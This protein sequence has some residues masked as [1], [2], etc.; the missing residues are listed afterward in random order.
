VLPAFSPD[1]SRIAYTRRSWDTF[2]APVT[3]GE[4]RLLLAN[5]T[6]LSWIDDRH[7][8]FS[9]IKT[10]HHLALIT[11]TESRTE[12]RDVYVPQPQEGMVHFSALSPD[13]KQALLGEMDRNGMLPCRLVPF[14]G[15][16]MGKPVGPIP[17][18]CEGVGW[19]PDGKWMYLSADAGSGTHIWRQRAAGG[20]PEQLTF[21]T[22][23][24]NGVAVTPDGKSLITSVGTTQNSVWVHDRDG[25][26]QVSAEGSAV[27]PFFSPDGK[28]LYYITKQREFGYGELWVTDL[29]SGRAERVLAG[30]LINRVSL[31]RDGRLIAYTTPDD[32]VWI[33]PLDR[34]LSPRKLASAKNWV[35][36]GSSGDVFFMGEDGA[37]N[38]LYRVRQ[39]GSGRQRVLE[40]PILRFISLSPDEHWA[41]VSVLD[42]ENPAGQRLYAYPIGG[43]KPITVCRRCWFS[44]APDGG[45][46][47]MSFQGVMPADTMT[48][49]VPLKA[50]A[51][52]PPLPP[53]GIRERADVDAIPGVRIVPEAR[54]VFGPGLS[55]W[56]W[57]RSNSHRNLYRIPLD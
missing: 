7:L 45:S 54:V 8:L 44:W 25:E 30:V 28:Q 4:P 13:R 22:A 23:T 17:S 2:V 27:D 55:T 37:A 39:D 48:A 50:G 3:G 36:F 15:S 51:M 43:G 26:R 21:G 31:S 42:P 1:S 40:Q 12:A 34:H 10:G 32:G 9:E 29:T 33:A 56:A 46:V 53:E 52:L 11:A 47:W 16:S 18:S 19:S 6:G 24:E 38:H 20:A 49:A 57:M 5:A 35:E 41:A 14:D